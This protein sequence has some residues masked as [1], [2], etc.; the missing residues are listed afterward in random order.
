MFLFIGIPN[1]SL[2]KSDIILITFCLWNYVK[3]ALSSTWNLSKLL[4]SIWLLTSV[5]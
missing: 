5:C 2:S 4:L 1:I 3:D